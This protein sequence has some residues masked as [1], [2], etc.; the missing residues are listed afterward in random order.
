MVLGS[1]RRK[2]NDW[3]GQRLRIVVERLEECLDLLDCVISGIKYYFLGA[4]VLTR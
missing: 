1:C 2:L 4:G 3:G